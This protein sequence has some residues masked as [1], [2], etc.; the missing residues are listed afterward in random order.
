MPTLEEA[1][2]LRSA[3]RILRSRS[4]RPDGIGMRVLCILLE[5]QAD[6]IEKEASS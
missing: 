3:A 6:K 2:V 4:T 1:R 5:D